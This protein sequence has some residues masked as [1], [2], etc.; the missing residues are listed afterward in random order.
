MF[1]RKLFSKSPEQLRAKA[2]QLL[3]GG[4]YAEARALYEDV[5]EALPEDEVNRGER[6]FLVERIAETGNLLGKLNLDEADAAMRNGN[7]AKMEEHLRLALAL[8]DDVAVREKAESMLTREQADVPAPQPA[9]THSGHHNC[10]GCSPSHHPAEQALFDHVDG[11]VSQEEQ[12][13]LLI[14]TLPQPLPQRYALMGEKFAYAYLLAHAERLEEARLVFEELAAVEDNDILLCE[15]ALTL[16][17]LGDPSRCETVL[18]RAIDLNNDNPLCHLSLAQLY[19]AYQHYDVAIAQLKRMLEHQLLPEQSLLML[20]D[21]YLLHGDAE[22]GLDTYAK[23]M[24]VPALRK[25]TAERLVPLLHER[26]R[27]DEAAFLVKTY[28]KG[29]C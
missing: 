9:S 10:S 24:E 29:C 27:S 20:G 4:R 14:A 15:Y 3:A 26:G 22:S 16:F 1:L 8:A 2:D 23:A 19:I 5:L 13:Q 18:K 7:H 28:L 11:E 25:A 12:F 17:R 21:V 6:A